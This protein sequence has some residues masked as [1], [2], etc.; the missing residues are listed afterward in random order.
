M[1]YM[2]RCCLLI[3]KGMPHVLA[4]CRMREFASSV[5]TVLKLS[6]ASVTTVALALL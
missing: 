6:A 3:T 1:L 5:M 2:S 4:I